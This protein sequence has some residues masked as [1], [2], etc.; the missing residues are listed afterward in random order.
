MKTLR[1]LGMV[2]LILFFSRNALS[3]GTPTADE[4]ISKARMAYYYQGNDARVKINMRGETRSL[5]R[6]REFII[7]RL[8]EEKGGG[9]KYYVYYEKPSN[10]RGTAYMVWKHPNR[11]DDR[12]LYIP[13][14]SLVNRIAASDK[15]SAFA[16]SDFVYE[17][18]SGRNIGADNHE[19]ISD[20]GDFY[21]VKSVPK[22]PSSEDF[23]YYISEIRKDDFI[24]VKIVYYD[25][26][27]KPM[28]AIEVEEIKDIQGHPTVTRATAQGLRTGGE[29]RITLSEVEYDIGLTDDVFTESYLQS[30]PK[31]WIE[32]KK[33]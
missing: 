32:W 24:P 29:T 13:V 7:L 17:D 5:K 18:I 14:L 31:Q 8:N 23:A 22:D 16:E 3:A 9:Q 20:K 12:W 27:E 2:S 30:P 26:I 25:I 33:N 10:I 11:D 6:E 1:S 28:R 21:T 4:I 19:L 15:Q